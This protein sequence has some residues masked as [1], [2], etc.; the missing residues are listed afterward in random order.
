MGEE[1]FFVSDAT[2]AYLSCV[3]LQT[4]PDASQSIAGSVFFANHGNEFNKKTKNQT[5]TS[6]KLIRTMWFIIDLDAVIFAGGRLLLLAHCPALDPAASLCYPKL[7][8]QCSVLDRL[9]LSGD[10]VARLSPG[11]S[12]A[13]AAPRQQ[14]SSQPQLFLCALLLGI[15][16][17]I[18]KVATSR[19]T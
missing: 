14:F 16:R 17:L 10:Q 6:R 13:T 18:C 5:K 7:L 4:F 11:T 19:S 3:S 8:Y 12:A 15:P 2:S 9:G 1:N